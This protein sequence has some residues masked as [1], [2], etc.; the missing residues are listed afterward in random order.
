VLD[1]QPIPALVQHPLSV[2]GIVHYGYQNA[3]VGINEREES[4]RSVK[5]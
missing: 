3:V 4:P 2:S 5:E 1:R